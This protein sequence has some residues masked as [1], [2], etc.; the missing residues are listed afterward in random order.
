[1]SDADLIKL[2]QKLLEK[3]RATIDDLIQGIKTVDKYN[4]RLAEI[5]ALIEEYYQ[6]RIYERDRTIGLN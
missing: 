3:Q 4:Q 6:Q 5:V 1:M 2:Q